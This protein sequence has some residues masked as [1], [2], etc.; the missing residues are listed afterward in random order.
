MLVVQLGWWLEYGSG[1]RICKGVDPTR[2]GASVL[3]AIR[4]MFGREDEGL[5]DQW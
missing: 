3:D 4:R 1:G 5:V 2:D